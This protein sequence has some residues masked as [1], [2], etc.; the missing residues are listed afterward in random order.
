[1]LTEPLLSYI[2]NMILINRRIC[3]MLHQTNSSIWY[4]N[5]DHQQADEETY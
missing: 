3:L 4:G 2:E 1:M 5:I